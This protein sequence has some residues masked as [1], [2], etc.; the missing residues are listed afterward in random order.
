LIAIDPGVHYCGVATYEQGTLLLGEY[1][2]VLETIDYLKAHLDCKTNLVIVE[3]PQIYPRAKGDPND[4]IDLAVVVGQV[5]SFA[6]DYTTYKPRE[7]KGQVPKDVMVNRI[8]SKLSTKEISHISP[9]IRT[10]K[11]HNVYDAIGIGLFALG[12]LKNK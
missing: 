10:S 6:N 12:R 2:S 4:L 1:Y 3:K 8:K 11:L 9:R 5:I 7:W